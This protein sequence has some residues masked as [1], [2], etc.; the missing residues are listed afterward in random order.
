MSKRTLTLRALIR[1]ALAKKP[2]EPQKVRLEEKTFACARIKIPI[3]D[4]DPLSWLASQTIYPKIYHE[5]FDP[6][7]KIATVGCVY[8]MDKVPLLSSCNPPVRFFGGMDFFE[9]KYSTWKGVPSCLYLLPLVEVEK[10]EHA[11]YL[12]INQ[13]DKNLDLKE[14]HFDLS[15][16]D[17]IDQKPIK[18][19]NIPTYSVWKKKIDESLNSIKRNLFDKIVLA[20]ASLFEF[21]KS[22]NPLTFCKTL[23]AKSQKATIFAYQFSREESFVGATPE[24]LYQR[25]KR[26]IKTVAIGGTRP[27]GKNKQEDQALKEELLLSSK[28]RKEVDFVKKGIKRA[29][30]PLCLSFKEESQLQIIQ[31]STVQHLF[32]SFS[33]QLKQTVTDALILQMLHPTPAVGGYP[34]ETV[35]KEIRKVETF[36]RGWYAAPIGWISKEGAHLSVAIRS[37]LIRDKEL[38]LF[39]GT[40]IVPG[41]CPKKEWEEL[42]HKISQFNFSKQN[43]R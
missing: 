21:E 11:T 13:T 24:I 25:A 39:A 26:S 6:N 32:H 43:E 10:K 33:G 31:T 4:I 28:D 14:L 27:R 19:R 15:E 20:R 7:C 1:Q 16:I 38:C 17:L 41:S 42:G 5:T 8:K 12:Y 23:R 18:A 22:L 2:F 40:G 37:A 3:P 30:E 29:L 34:N 36:D 9:R 35:M